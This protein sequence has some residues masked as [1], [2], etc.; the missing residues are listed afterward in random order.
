MENFIVISA[1]LSFALFLFP[2]FITV[3]VVVS[4]KKIGFSL[5]VFSFFK[6]AGGYVTFH[7]DGYCIHLSE[8]KA[9]FVEYGSMNEERK[10]FAV[11]EGFQLYRLHITAELNKKSDYALPLTVFSESVLW[12]AFARIKEKRKYLSLKSGVLLSDNETFITANTVT[13]FN[14]FVLARATVKIIM[15]RIIT[16]IWQKKQKIRS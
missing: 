16:K 11:T 9:F 14:G 6:V 13:V 2:V 8:K 4:G 3:S 12:E 1:F 5:Y 10:K 7:K 15:G